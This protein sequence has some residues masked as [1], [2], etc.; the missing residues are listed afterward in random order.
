MSDAANVPVTRKYN[1]SHHTEDTAVGQQSNVDLSLDAKITHGE[2][3]VNVSGDTEINSSL[4]ADIA[5]NEEPVTILIENNSNSDNPE[6]HVPV[7]VNGRGAEVLSNGRWLE[8]TWL[9]IGIELTTKRKYVEVLARSKSTTIRTQHEDAN[10][11]R[12]RNEVKRFTKAQYPMSILVDE[13]PKGRAWLS[14]IRTG[15]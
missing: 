12:P 5:F 7:Q 1:R 15:L 13:N 8:I 6:T 9:P 10:V 2:S 4:L 11:E 3:L 14:A